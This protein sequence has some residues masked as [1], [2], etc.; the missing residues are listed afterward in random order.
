MIAPQLKTALVYN[1]DGV[2]DALS[3]WEAFCLLACSPFV[4]RMIP[5]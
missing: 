2:D 4:N 5:S 1:L 3:S